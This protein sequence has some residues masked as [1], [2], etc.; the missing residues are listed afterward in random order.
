MKPKI[1]T[2]IIMPA[3][4]PPPK[5]KESPTG[6]GEEYQELTFEGRPV[7]LSIHVGKNNGIGIH[8]KEDGTLVITN[9]AGVYTTVA[10]QNLR[11]E[12]SSP[13]DKVKE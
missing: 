6:W 12:P 10:P 5:V 9:Y 11:L 8:I 2:R 13:W 1:T 4:T 7:D 3:G